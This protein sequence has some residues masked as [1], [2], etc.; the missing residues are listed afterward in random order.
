MLFGNFV[1]GLSIIAIVLAAQLNISSE[2]RV[3]IIVSSAIIVE[4]TYSL[5]YG[6]VWFTWVGDVVDRNDRSLFRRFELQPRHSVTDHPR[7]HRKTR[8]VV[9]L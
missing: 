7:K 3:V 8:P 2:I 6:T 1:S 5:S 4:I 9:Y